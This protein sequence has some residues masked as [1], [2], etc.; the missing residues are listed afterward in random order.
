MKFIENG[1]TPLVRTRKME[2]AKTGEFSFELSADEHSLLC[3][4]GRT[5]V[6]VKSKSADDAR[7]KSIS[8]DGCLIKDKCC[9]KGKAKSLTINVEQFKTL[10]NLFVLV[11]SDAGVEIYSHRGNRCESP[12]GHIKANLHGKKFST[13]GLEKCNAILKLYAILYNLRRLLTILE[14][15][16]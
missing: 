9:P 1:C 7:F 14:T 11:D 4:T 16:D 8:C 13:T 10:Q 3:P 15:V 12:H 2:N 6:K 5:L